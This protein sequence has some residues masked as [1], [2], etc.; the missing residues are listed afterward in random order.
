MI[1]IVTVKI[2]LQGEMYF[3]PFNNVE[4]AN[5]FG[6]RMFGDRA[7]WSAQVLREAK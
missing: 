4:I 2:P 1:Y 3:G 6:Q 5:Q 7:K